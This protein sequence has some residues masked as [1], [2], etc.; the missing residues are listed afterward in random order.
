MTEA[1]VRFGGWRLIGFAD[2]KVAKVALVRCDCGQISR[3]SYEALLSGAHVSCPS[4]HPPQHHAS[5]RGER[6]FASVLAS[7]EGR[8]AKKKHMGRE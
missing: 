5:E 7:S 3:V 1:E 2:A 4:C 6:S 8:S